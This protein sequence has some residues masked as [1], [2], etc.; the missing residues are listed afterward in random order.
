MLL[1]VNSLVQPMEED[2]L[3]AEMVELANELSQRQGFSDPDPEEFSEVVR[4]IVENIPEFFESE[5]RQDVPFRMD[6]LEDQ[7]GDLERHVSHDPELNPPTRPLEEDPEVAFGD[8][9]VQLLIAGYSMGID[10]ERASEIGLE[11]I[12]DR[13]GYHKT[14][15]EALSGIA[16]EGETG[17]HHGVVG[18]DILVIREFSE[19]HT[20]DVGDYD[21]IVSEIGG[22]TSHMAM[23]AREHGTPFICGVNSITDH[24]AE[25]DAITLD[26]ETAEVTPS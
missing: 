6:V 1:T 17:Q 2:E 12:I 19:D 22:R 21:F 11:R 24:V 3:R 25:G 14:G 13:E 10:F 20:P 9:L 5:Y 23:V 16:A 18:E 15:D 8:A 4:S 26:F 7:I